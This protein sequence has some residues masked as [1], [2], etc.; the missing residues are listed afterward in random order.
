[1][2]HQQVDC[3]RRWTI[4]AATC[5]VQA[6]SQLP[7]VWP[8]R[9]MR[10]A[11]ARRPGGR[12]VE[13]TQPRGVDTSMNHRIASAVAAV[14]AAGPMPAVLAQETDQRTRR[15]D[16]HGTAPDGEPAGRPARHPGPVRRHACPAQRHDDGRVHQVPAQRVDGEHGA[17]PEQRLHA[18]P[19]RR[20]ARHPGFRHERHLAER[21]C[22]PRR[23]VDPGPGPQSRPLHGRPRA[24]RGP[25]RPAGHAVRRRRPGGRAALHHEQAAARRMDQQGVGRL[26]GHV[27]WQ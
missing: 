3:S 24:H 20:R 5:Y 11:T 22:V 23:A 21:R 9:R 15:G 26:L 8:W 2:Q 16:R 7:V 4:G 6:G 13:D 25:D 17:G 19:Q 14:L 18:R 1:M 12:C 27:A 10:R